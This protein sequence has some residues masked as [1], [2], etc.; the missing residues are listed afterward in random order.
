MTDYDAIDYYNS[1]NDY[2][3]KDLYDNA[4]E[5]Y[6]KAIQLD[7]NLAQAYGNRGL[8]YLNK[9]Q[10]DKAIEDFN[11]VIALIPDH[12]FGYINR[13]LAHGYKGD[14]EMSIEDCNKAIALDSDD[15]SAYINRALAYSSKGENDK[16]IE[17]CNKALV[18]DPDNVDAYNFLSELKAKNKAV[19]SNSMYRD[20]DRSYH[21]VESALIKAAEKC[22]YKYVGSSSYG[23]STILKIRESG[24]WGFWNNE[25]ITILHET[26]DTCKVIILFN[27]PLAEKLFEAMDAFL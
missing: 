12:P 8:T 16:A 14:Y 27:R 18:L 5:D 11:K 19:E 9:S 21:D 17:N 23:T 15:P 24:K 22:G 6:N 20:F 7:P 13:A 1:G 25:E 10:Y 26:N 4:I 2:K 3:S